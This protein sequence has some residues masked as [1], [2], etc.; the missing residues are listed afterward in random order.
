MGKVILSLY[1]RVLRKGVIRTMSRK[2][3]RQSSVQ[4]LALVAQDERRQFLQRNR[5]LFSILG[6]VLVSWLT[7]MLYSQWLF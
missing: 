1:N 2:I 3:T 4:V 6:L 5:S 7:I